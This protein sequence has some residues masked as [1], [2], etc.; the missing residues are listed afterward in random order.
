MH[1]LSTGSRSS[2]PSRVSR[3]PD[4]DARWAAVR[5]RDPEAESEFVF[6]VSTT[7]VYCRSTCAARPAR[8]ENVSFFA[9]PLAA[10]AAGYRPCKRCRP[11]LPSRS[12][13]EAALIAE[14]CRRIERSEEEPALATLAEKAGLSPHHF[15]RIFKRITGV[16]PKA[17]A[18]ANR[19]NKV[20][21]NLAAGSGVTETIYASGFNSSGRFYEAVSGMLGMTPSVYK[22]GGEGEEICH[23]IG[24]SSLGCVLVAATRRGVCA[25]MMDDDPAVLRADLKARFPKATLIEPTPAFAELVAE[26]VRFVDDPARAEGL[27]LPLDIRGT[28]FQRRVWEA[29]RAIPAGETASY[30]E[31]AQRVGSPHAVRA[32]ASA[33]AANKIAVAIPC[34]R[35]IATNGGL[36]GYRWGIERKRRLLERERG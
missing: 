30:A 35:V 36:A 6:A 7:G 34:H 20:Q 13:R 2:L 15:H 29:L 17:Y 28:T 10:E 19:H 33:C 9:T 26:V 25:I 22:K 23:A 24:R 32:V 21:A 18:A 14:A 31:I 5:G 27:N 16:T 4:D 11:D 8:R 1:T 12:E 3:F